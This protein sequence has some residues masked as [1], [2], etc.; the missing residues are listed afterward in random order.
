MAASPAD[1]EATVAMCLQAAEANR[2]TPTRRGNVVELDAGAGEDILIAADLHGNRLN[3][4]RLCEAADLPNHPRRH[5]VMQEIC[6]GGPSYPAGG[7]CMSHLLLEDAIRLKTEYPERFHFLLSNHELAELTDF[8]IAKGRKML[9]LAFRCGVTELYGAAAEQVREAYQQFIRSCPLAIRIQQGLF[10]SHSLPENVDAQGFDVSVFER[11]LEA[12]DLQQGGSVF[13]LLW[14]RDYRAANAVAFARLVGAEMLIHGHEPC[15]DGCSMPNPRQ[16]I[17]DCCGG[18]SCYLLLPI[19]K[20]YTR[21]EVVARIHK[22][23]AAARPKAVQQFL[24][25]RAP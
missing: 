13:R 3:F 10:V 2:S 7:G 23:H 25:Q 15:P 22:L 14:G 4:Q 8:P 20:P 12:E 24:T 6:H 19:G 11:P 16:V 18:P 1:A 5:L 21:E 9:N 17:L